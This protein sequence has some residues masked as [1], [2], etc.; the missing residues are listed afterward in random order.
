MISGEDIVSPEEGRRTAES[1][2]A[3]Y[4][5]TSVW[6]GY[7]VTDVFTNVA[8]SALYSKRLKN[9]FSV[10]KNIK[11]VR[12]PHCQA[13]YQ[14]PTPPAPIVTVKTSS[15]NDDKHS[16]LENVPYSDVVFIAQGVLI[17]AHKICLSAASPVFEELF[18]SVITHPSVSTKHSSGGAKLLSDTARLLDNEELEASSTETINLID[19]TGL[20]AAAREPE[21]NPAFESYQIQLMDDISPQTAT[22]PQKSKQIVITLNSCITPAA[23]RG[24]LVYLYTGECTEDYSLLTDVCMAAKQIGLNDLTE[25]CENLLRNAAYKNSDIQNKQR[26]LR[27]QK[28]YDLGIKQEYFTGKIILMRFL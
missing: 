3:D 20:A 27:K 6:A 24:V 10:L 9:I 19:L 23:F 25:I 26:E 4:Y 15:L 13:P 5:E 8:R 18:T 2:G 12:K 16:L 1:M 17:R 14:L 21:L 7:G 11:H 22:S 28:I